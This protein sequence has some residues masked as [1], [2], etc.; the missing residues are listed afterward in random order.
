M[1]P[2]KK[3][4]KSIQEAAAPGSLLG[5]SK[6]VQYEA[7]PGFSGAGSPAKMKAVAALKGAKKGVTQAQHNREPKG[8]V[9]D[10]AG[11][12]KSDGEGG[13]R[14]SYLERLKKRK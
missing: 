3:K 1:L 5:A 10:P 8:K 7:N 12:M 6:P 9:T 4:K 13:Y 11:F 14:K 2:I